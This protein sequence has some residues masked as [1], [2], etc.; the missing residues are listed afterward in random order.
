[1]DFWFEDIPSG[2]PGRRTKE[3][4]K[5]RIEVMR[6]AEIGL[7]NFGLCEST[8][9]RKPGWPDWANFRLL[10]DSVLYY[11]IRPNFRRC[12][13]LENMQNNFEKKMFGLHFGWF[14]SQNHHP[15]KNWTLEKLFKKF[16]RVEESNP[17]P[18]LKSIYSCQVSRGR[19]ERGWLC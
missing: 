15:A 16:V 1:L 9:K 2:N 11:G 4:E 18:V 5:K 17:R 10:G 3:S 7:K 6:W 13:V 14:L 8:Y 19:L 12:F